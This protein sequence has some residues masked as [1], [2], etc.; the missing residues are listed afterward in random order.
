MWMRPVAYWH[1]KHQVTTSKRLAASTLTGTARDES[2]V[3]LPD[4]L[5]SKR[6]SKID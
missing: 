3:Y 1:A 5:E 4:I 6:A 2:D